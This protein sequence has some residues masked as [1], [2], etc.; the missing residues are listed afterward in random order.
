[1]R[2]VMCLA[3]LLNFVLG[4]P[5]P[6]VNNANI[7]TNLSKIQIG[8]KFSITCHTNFTINATLQKSKVIFCLE[9]GTYSDRADGKSILIPS[10]SRSMKCFYWYYKIE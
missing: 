1:M 9:N 8:Q 6:I 10:C 5:V 3:K 2:N 7:N 4:C